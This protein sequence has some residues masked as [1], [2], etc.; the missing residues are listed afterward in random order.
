MKTIHQWFDEYS[1]SHQNKTNKLIHW[2]CVPTI[3]FSIIALASEVKFTFLNH[4]LPDFFQPYNHLGTPLVLVALLFYLRLSLK[5]SVGLLLFAILCL[6]L[7]STLQQLPIPVWQ[8]ALILFVIAWLGQFYGHK[9][10]GKKPS[11]FK[12]LAF[13]LIGPAW[14][15]GFV[16]KGLGL[17]Y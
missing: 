12:D 15:M 2:V 3:F 13:L 11:F 16:Y 8:S 17:T 10:E 1:E 6:A 7:I 4:T 5:I 14:L 9:V